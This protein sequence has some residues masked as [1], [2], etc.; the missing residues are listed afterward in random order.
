MWKFL[1]PNIFRRSNFH[2]VYSVK[3]TSQICLENWI[4]KIEDDW[5]FRIKYLF[6][7]VLQAPYDGM[8]KF[9]MLGT[10]DADLFVW[11]GNEILIESSLQRDF[12]YYWYYFSR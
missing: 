3:S 9:T 10:V 5:K 12:D 4:G 7:F 8:Y 6:L 11:Y 2:Y 1:L